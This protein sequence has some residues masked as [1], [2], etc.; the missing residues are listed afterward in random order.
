MTVPKKTDKFILPKSKPKVLPYITTTKEK[1][2]AI[3][4]T[5]IPPNIN[6]YE[7]INQIEEN[8]H[9]NIKRCDLLLLLLAIR[10]KP[11]RIVYID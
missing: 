10:L 6:K 2:N 9:V 11:L 7:L 8:Y 4:V 5:S 3:S 1:N